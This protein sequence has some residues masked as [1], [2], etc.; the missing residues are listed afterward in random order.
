MATFGHFPETDEIEDISIEYLD[1]HAISSWESVMHDLV[2]TPGNRPDAVIQLLSKSGLMVKAEKGLRITSKGFQFLLQ[3]LHLQVWSLLLQYLDLAE[4]FE[5][6]P[7]DVLNFIFQLGSLELGRVGR[8][9]YCRII[10]S[11]I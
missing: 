11:L 2:G 6:D 9:S 8:Q 7:V 4:T 3:D 5:M 10:L 1:R